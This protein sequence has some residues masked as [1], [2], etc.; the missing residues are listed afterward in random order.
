MRNYKIKKII[1]FLFL[2]LFVVF[3]SDEVKAAKKF[4]PKKSLTRSTSRGGVGIIPAVVRYRGDKLGILLSFTNFNGINSASYSFTYNTNGI[5][6][7][8]GGTVTAQN[9][10][11]LQR[12]LL[13][14]TC[15]TAVCTYHY[16]LSNAKLIITAKMTDGKILTKA[17]RIKTYR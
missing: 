2:L 8:V 11:T 6:Q 3:P 14:G 13:F 17:Y 5:S 10:P 1:L 16:N 12:E 4:I 7:G 15:S 9:N